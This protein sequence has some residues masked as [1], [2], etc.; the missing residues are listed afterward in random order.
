MS[1]AIACRRSQAPV[2]SDPM[3]LVVAHRLRLLAA[4]TTSPAA[5]LPLQAGLCLG[6]VP[7][8][9]HRR[10]APANRTAAAVTTD[11]RNFRSTQD[12]GDPSTHAGAML[13]AELDQRLGA[14]QFVERFGTAFDAP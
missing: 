13:V 14:Q 10:S 4:I 8:C 12:V 3:L 9:A 5:T 7:Q 11:R 1:S 6:C 2:A